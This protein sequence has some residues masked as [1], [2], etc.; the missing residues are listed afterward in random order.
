MGSQSHLERYMYERSQSHVTWNV[1]NVSRCTLIINET[2]LS[3][4]PSDPLSLSPPLWVSAG[5]CNLHRYLQ[6]EPRTGA[7]PQLPP[8]PARLHSHLVVDQLCA[9]STFTNL[10]DTALYR[11]W[12]GLTREAAMGQMT[13]SQPAQHPD[14]R[15]KYKAL[16]FRSWAFG[17]FL[18]ILSIFSQSPPCSSSMRLRRSFS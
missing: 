3:T 4:H 18:N 2:A 8:S 5:V 7:C 12:Q 15:P 9:R 11:Q 6:V 14:P 17:S 1:T 16:V 13:T 10:P